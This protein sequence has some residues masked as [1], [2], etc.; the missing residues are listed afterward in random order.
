MLVIQLT[1]V[2]AGLAEAGAVQGGGGVPVEAG[3]RDQAKPP[4][5]PLRPCGEV[6]I[7][8]VERRGDRQVLRVHQGQPVFGCCQ[9]SG[10]PGGRPGGMVAQLAGQHPDRQRQV[11]AQPGYLPARTRCRAQVR[12]ASQPR[13]QLRRFP[14]GQR[15]QADHR[16]VLQRGQPAAAG[17]QHQAARAAGQQR[18]DLLVTGR[19]I[20]QQQDLLAR[21]LV[22]PPAGPGVQPG[23]DLR[24]GHPGGQQQAGQRIGRVHRPMPGGVGMQR[25][26]ELPVR[27][28]P[29]Q[30]VRRVHREGSLADP[31]HPADRVN[32]HHPAGRS[33]RANPAYQPRKLGPAASEGGDI[34]RQRPGRRGRERPR[35]TTPGR[36]HVG[37]RPA[38]ARRRH[39]PPAHRP[40][41]AQRIGQLAGGILMG[42]AVDSPFQVTDRP[43]GQA[44][45]FGQLLLRQ[46]SLGPQ[47]PQ[48]LR[49]P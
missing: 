45:T 29:G 17:D 10:Q 11:P 24:R 22:T 16:G 13:Q 32:A 8:Q 34:T 26:E 6:G 19:V 43:R 33:Q 31:G 38:S 5:Q 36:Q 42:G 18:P 3:A 7:G 1:K 41:Q 30:P 9:V 12:A 44:R 40:G 20:E 21:H 46:P 23:R 47:L 48:Q 25:Q 39:E 35:P 27:E 4:E 49:E 28:G 14:R 2:P 37:G 15:V